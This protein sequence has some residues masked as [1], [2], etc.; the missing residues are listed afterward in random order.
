M[1][2]IRWLLN[3][4]YLLGLFHREQLRLTGTTHTLSIPVITRWTSHF[5]SISSVLSQARPLRSLVMFHPESFE[6]SAGRSSEQVQQVKG[7]MR[8]IEDNRFWEKL[9]E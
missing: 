9:T 2:I 5:L 8:T 1:D 7:I 4:S 3:H 6:A